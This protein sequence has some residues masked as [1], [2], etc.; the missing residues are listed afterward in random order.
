M[1]NKS[2]VNG[3]RSALLA[4]EDTIHERADKSRQYVKQLKEL[5]NGFGRHLKGGYSSVGS[6]TSYEMLEKMKRS[7]AGME[8]ALDKCDDGVS[9]VAGRAASN[10]TAATIAAAE[11]G[12]NSATVANAMTDICSELETQ[13]ARLRRE[14]E[15]LNS[16][17]GAC[18]PP[19]RTRAPLLTPHPP[20]PRTGSLKMEEEQR[21][22]LQ[23]EYRLAN[24]RS[25]GM[26]DV[27]Q[28]E[29]DGERST[30]KQLQRR[31]DECVMALKNCE[32]DRV[33]EAMSRPRSGGG[34]GGGGW[35]GS[36]VGGGGGGWEERFVGGAREGAFGGAQEGAR[37]TSFGGARENPFGSAAEQLPVPPPTK[38]ASPPRRSQLEEEQEQQQPP[39]PPQA[40]T[41]SDDEV[42]FTRLLQSSNEQLLSAL[43]RSVEEKLESVVKRQT[44]VFLRTS[45]ELS[46][47][48]E[49]SEGE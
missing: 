13:N 21:A 46:F 42:M 24:V 33:K 19:H 25:R 27:A 49:S 7:L 1:K 45:K 36:G 10:V 41:L 38:S 20:I 8:D 47:G 4:V 37:E 6:Y 48:G 14:I 2:A 31:L 16:E 22:K 18:A 17:L 30:V 23:P 15:R 39:P 5:I 28:K 9:D 11:S 29:L 40:P 3:M 35:G 32:E 43:Q 44:E 12:A 26:A 34:G